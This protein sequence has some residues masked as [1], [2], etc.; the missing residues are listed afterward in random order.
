M[1]TWFGSLL[2]IILPLC[3]CGMIPIVLRLI[4]KG[5][6]AC[7]GIV[8]IAVGLILNLVVFGARTRGK[9]FPFSIALSL[10]IAASLVQPIIAIIFFISVYIELPH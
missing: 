4:R 10:L 2:G 6:P 8:Y 1:G 3:E 5:L 7:I 9:P